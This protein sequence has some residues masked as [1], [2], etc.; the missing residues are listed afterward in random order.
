MS[1]P[2]AFTGSPVALAFQHGG[3]KDCPSVS[4]A[5]AGREFP[6]VPSLVS[7]SNI[8]PGT[9]GPAAKAELKAG[10]W[11]NAVWWGGVCT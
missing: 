4:W 9:I 11:L 10:N 6:L 8:T 3:G 2:H 5:W 1:K 7:V